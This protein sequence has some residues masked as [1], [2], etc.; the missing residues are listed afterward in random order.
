MFLNVILK[1]AIF[2]ECLKAWMRECRW[3]AKDES[4]MPLKV[5]LLH[6]HCLLKI[7]ACSSHHVEANLHAN[8]NQCTL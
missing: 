6:L 3:S 5:N 8:F 4:S 1:G 7:P 2:S